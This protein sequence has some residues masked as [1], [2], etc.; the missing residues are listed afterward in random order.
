MNDQRFLNLCFALSIV[1]GVCG[2]VLVPGLIVVAR[3]AIGSL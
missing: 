2:C 1:F 3:I